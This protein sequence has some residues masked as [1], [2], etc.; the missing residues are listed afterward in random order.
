ML[1]ATRLQVHNAIVARV[2]TVSGVGPVFDRVRRPKQ[3]TEGQIVELFNDASGI[4]NCVFVRYVGLLRE[5]S[6]FDDTISLSYVFELEYR[7]AWNERDDDDSPSELIFNSFLDGLDAAFTDYDLGF[8]PGVSSR[9]IEIL[10]PISRD[11]QP[12]YAKLCHTAYPR[13]VVSV[14][15]C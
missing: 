4:L 11:P 15:E 3:E 2:R 6:S 8:D 5:T 9:G 7:Y 14:S 13:L 12:F 1:A 10:Q